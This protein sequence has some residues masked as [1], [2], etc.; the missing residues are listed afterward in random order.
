MSGIPMQPNLDLKPH[1]RHE[2]RRILE[3]CLP[4]YEVWAFGSRTKRTAKPYSDL[5]LAVISEKPLS[6]AL[7]AYLQQSFEESDLTIKVDVVD[8]A[9]TSAT[10]RTIIEETKVVIQKGTG[11]E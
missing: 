6:I 3:K 8:W 5:D 11:D 9:K 7:M 10:F 4:G 2:V 1:D